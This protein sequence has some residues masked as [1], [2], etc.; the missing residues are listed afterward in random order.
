MCAN[1]NSQGKA[2]VKLKVTY[3]GQVYGPDGPASHTTT[4]RPIT[5]RSWWSVVADLGE[6]AREGFS[7][8]RRR[9]GNELPWE[10]YDLHYGSFEGFRVYDAPYVVVRCS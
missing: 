8:F 7:F 9:G 5:F 2:T 1:H 4:T 6:D 10:P 3:A